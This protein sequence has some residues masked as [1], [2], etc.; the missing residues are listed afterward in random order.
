VAEVFWK[1]PKMKIMT[2]IL[3]IG[4]LFLATSFSLTISRP[5]NAQSAAPKRL[6]PNALVS[7]L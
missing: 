6:S 3:P 5:V 4:L 2:P 1:E 7:D